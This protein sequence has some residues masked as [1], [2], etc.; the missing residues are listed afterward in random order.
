MPTSQLVGVACGK[1][2]RLLKL[3]KVDGILELR[4]HFT[5]HAMRKLNLPLLNA[6]KEGNQDE[7]GLTLY[8]RF[9]PGEQ[10]GW[11]KML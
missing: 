9:L 1:V 7:V 8:E 6:A 3:V 4:P 2:V 10:C 11:R 5:E